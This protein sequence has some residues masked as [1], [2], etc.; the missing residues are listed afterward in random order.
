MEGRGVRRREEGQGL[1]RRRHQLAGSRHSRQLCEVVLAPGGWCWLRGAETDSMQRGC[2][3]CPGDSTVRAGRAALW[4]GWGLGERL[5]PG[6]HHCWELVCVLTRKWALGRCSRKFVEQTSKYACFSVTHFEI[7]VHIFL[8][9]LSRPL[10]SVDFKNFFFASREKNHVLIS[11]SVNFQH[12]P[13]SD[14]K[15]FTE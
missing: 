5:P 1:P 11:S 14:S 9:T 7:H 12:S 10:G 8:Q 13:H 6:T 2:D 15:E 4:R 3:P